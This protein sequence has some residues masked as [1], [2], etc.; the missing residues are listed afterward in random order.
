MDRELVPLDPDG[1]R[2]E[3][4]DDSAEPLLP[5]PVDEDEEAREAAALL[6]ALSPTAAVNE[7]SFAVRSAAPVATNADPALAE[8]AVA[9]GENADPASS[10]LLLL[11]KPKPKPR[12]KLFPLF[13]DL[14]MTPPLRRGS[15][16]PATGDRPPMVLDVPR[17]PPL[18]PPPPRLPLLPAPL[19]RPKLRLRPSLD[20]GPGPMAFGA[21]LLLPVLA[22]TGAVGFDSLLAGSCSCSVVAAASSLEEAV[23]SGGGGGGATAVDCPAPAPAAPAA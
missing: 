17:L 16:P 9:V 14:R 13:G 21:A 4:H 3:R 6:L 2:D 8:A 11:S 18:P 1:A 7:L 12:E 20:E 5:A 10:P 23:D 22:L 19:P 15:P